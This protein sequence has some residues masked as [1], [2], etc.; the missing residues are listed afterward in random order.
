VLQSSIGEGYLALQVDE[1]LG[2][3]PEPANAEVTWYCGN[4]CEVTVKGNA[5]HL[6][7]NELKDKPVQPSCK[8]CRHFEDDNPDQEEGRCTCFE[9]DAY[10]PLTVHMTCKF[11][12]VG[13]K[14][15]TRV[16][17]VH[18]NL[19]RG[20]EALDEALGEEGD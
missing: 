8:S 6:I 14:Q 17:K 16:K 5:R 10:G 3:N 7:V 19:K 4:G 20:K 9:S 13:E 2:C 1:I 11:F 15:K 18:A 12:S